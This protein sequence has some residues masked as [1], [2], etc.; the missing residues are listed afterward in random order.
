MELQTHD[1]QEG[2]LR[3]GVKAVI[4]NAPAVSEF[5]NLSDNGDA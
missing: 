5:E 3:L 2:A 4:F 1:V